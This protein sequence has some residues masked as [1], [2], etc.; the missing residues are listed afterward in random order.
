MAVVTRALPWVLP[1]RLSMFTHW[2]SAWDEAC[3]KGVIE[4]ATPEEYRTYQTY[5]AD[6]LRALLHDLGPDDALFHGLEQMGNK[7]V[8]LGNSSCLDE[9][10]PKLDYVVQC[11][12]YPTAFS[13]SS[14]HS[15][16]DSFKSW[17][18]VGHC[19]PFTSKVPN[20]GAATP[21]N[22]SVATG[23][24]ALAELRNRPE[25]LR[26]VVIDPR[27]TLD[28]AG[29]GSIASSRAPTRSGC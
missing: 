12:M 5:L 7:H 15:S 8:V 2:P 19:I 23:G 29:A 17:P 26:T 4:W 24:R 14:V 27:Y 16:Q 1:R 6:D 21:S 10:V 25:G 3:E 28:A 22:S 18:P 11:F 13:F 9:I 20:K